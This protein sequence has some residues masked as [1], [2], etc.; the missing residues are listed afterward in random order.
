MKTT[1]SC[2][3]EDEWLAFLEGT[4]DPQS[5][6]AAELHLDHCASCRRLTAAIVRARVTSSRLPDPVDHQTVT[7]AP[8]LEG[9]HLGRYLLLNRLGEGGMGLVYLA[10]DPELDRRVAIKL[11]RG[12]GRDSAGKQLRLAFEARALAKVSHPNVVQVLDVGELDGQLYVTMALLTGPSLRTWQPPNWREALLQLVAAGRGLQAAHDAGLVHGDFKPDNVLFSAQGVPVVT[13]FGLAAPID[14]DGDARS[15]GGT[16]AYMAPE[17]SAEH[18]SS[19]ASDQFAFA[20]TA[21]EVLGRVTD[22]PPAV[23]DTLQRGRATSAQARYPSLSAL[24]DALEATPRRLRRRRALMT[25]G[26]LMSLALAAWAGLERVRQVRCEQEASLVEVWGTTHRDRS[27]AAFEAS[28]VPS[29]RH[30]WAQV[31]ARFSS[32]VKDWATETSA[33]CRAAPLWGS[34]DLAQAEC[35][36]SIRD[37]LAALAVVLGTADDEV[38]RRGPQVLELLTPPR[39]CS[40]AERRLA[41]VVV[42]GAPE[43]KVMTAIALLATGRAAAAAQLLEALVPT[44]ERNHPIA[45]KAWEVYVHALSQSAAFAAEDAL[46]LDALSVQAAAARDDLMVAT[47]AHHALGLADR[48]TRLEEAERWVRFAEAM[49]RRLPARAP[50]LDLLTTRARAQVLLKL[51]RAA[52]AEQVIRTELETALASTGDGSF[53][54]ARALLDLAQVLVFQVKTDE[55]EA[56]ARRALA[57]WE[58]LVGNEH[59]ALIPVLTTL[60][61]TAMARG[62]ALKAL[63]FDDRCLA[64]ARRVYGPT[65]LA[66]APL[67]RNKVTASMQ[68]D[69]LESVVEDARLA[70]AV[71]AKHLSPDAPDTLTALAIYGSA[72]SITGNHASAAEA[73]TTA[74]HG[75][76]RLKRAVSPATDREIA[77]TLGC[78]GES[79]LQLGRPLEAQPYLER[80]VQ[81]FEAPDQVPVQ[82]GY[83]KLQLANCLAAQH[84]PRLIPRAEQLLKQTISDFEALG[85]ND[86]V[87]A[88]RALLAQMLN[89]ARARGAP[90]PP[91]ARE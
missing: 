36:T 2:L 27:R 46:L 16:P 40:T 76:E 90:G 4:T 29:A 6:R 80:A 23:I 19:R 8:R 43:G 20:V 72:H 60:A 66:M 3:L 55:A 63:E 7:P 41:S 32:A 9:A 54:M 35:L 67:L 83:S 15:W 18:R 38:V 70:H 74:L 52:E 73:C 33:V 78:I 81:M 89:D 11:I 84:D 13:D 71:Y 24:L 26:T 12:L 85:L 68:A 31:D 77:N 87:A 47:A 69:R 17:V 57:H 5:T 44:L 37:E 56:V 39:Q 88:T 45:P 58:A 22:V 86:D 34:G 53:E 50:S 65:D 14:G 48:R 61:G 64:I 30:L 28:S 79:L 62:Q 49:L 25:I 1:E 42:R 51:N 82:R 21:L 91:A 59:V 75:L 10:Y